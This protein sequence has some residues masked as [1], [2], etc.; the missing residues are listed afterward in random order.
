MRVSTRNL[1]ASILS[2][3]PSFIWSIIDPHNN[4]R[5]IMPAD[6]TSIPRLARMTHFLYL[7]VYLNNRAKVV[8][9]F[10]ALGRWLLRL[11]SCW[12][13]VVRARVLWRLSSSSYSLRFSL[14]EDS[15]IFCIFWSE[16]LN[17]DNKLSYYK[18]ALCYTALKLFDNILSWAL[19]T[20]VRFFAASAHISDPSPYLLFHQACQKC[21]AP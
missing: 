7:S 20:M 6:E 9:M 16:Q 12:V 5:T 10:L 17:Y 14:S 15:F 4:G 11:G 2:D 1:I 18:S 3:Y 8:L 21:L 13:K 19:G